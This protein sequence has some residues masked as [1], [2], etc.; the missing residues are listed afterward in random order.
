MGVEANE[1]GTIDAP[2][3]AID[4]DRLSDRK[5]VFFIEGVVEG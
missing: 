1:Q 3:L 5:D 4:A 2:C